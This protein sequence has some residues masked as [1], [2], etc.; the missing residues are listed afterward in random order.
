MKHLTSYFLHL[1]SYLFLLTSYLFLLTSCEYKELCYD[2]QHDGDY[3]AVLQLALKLDLDLDLDVS[4]EAHTKIVV[5]EYIKVCFY[6]PEGGT[7]RNTEF[8][9]GYGGPLHTPSGSYHM[10]AYSFGTEWTQI[11]GENDI[12]TIEAFTSDITTTKSAA[13]ARFTRNSEY[14]APGPII[15]SPDHL[16]LASEP[17]TIPVLTEDNNVV[18]IKANAATIVETYGFKV[19]NVEGLEYVSSVEA[20]VTNQAQSNFFGRGELNTNPA[21][22]YFPVEVNKKDRCLETT[23]N[24]FGKLPGES[25]SYLHL[26]LTSSDGTEVRI[27]TDITDQFEKPDNIIII[28]EPVVVPKPDNN[29]GGLAPKVDPWEEENHDVPIG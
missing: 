1:T 20:F 8:V 12:S 17:V 7:M 28:N 15:Y 5:P 29:S 23:F 10:L 25:R 9:K 22:I 21:T 26:L 24:T 4:F 13:L 19:L 3:T 6:D 2:H 14:E 18:T 27:S 16:L 11:R